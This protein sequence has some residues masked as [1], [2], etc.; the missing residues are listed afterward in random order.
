MDRLVSLRKNIPE[1]IYM[2]SIVL[3]VGFIIWTKLYIEFHLQEYVFD[4]DILNYALLWFSF[5]PYWLCEYR[6]FKIGLMVKYSIHFHQFSL[7]FFLIWV[8][9]YR[10][11]RSQGCEGKDGTIIIPHYHFH[12]LQLCISDVY[13]MFIIAVHVITRLLLDEIYPGN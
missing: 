12:S 4:F 9:F 1:I 13:L 10:H 2:R 5:I 7:I 8:S 11:W 6:G 3:Y